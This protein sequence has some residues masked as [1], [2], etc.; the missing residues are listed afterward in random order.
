MLAN[1]NSKSLAVLLI[2]AVVLVS[3]SFAT[4]PTDGTAIGNLSKKEAG[5][6]NVVSNTSLPLPPGK[7]TQL[8]N[9]GRAAKGARN[10]YHRDA[11]LRSAAGMCLCPECTARAGWTPESAADAVSPIRPVWYHQIRGAIHHGDPR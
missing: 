9:A 3:V 4:R 6:S 10:L 7:Q 8:Y 1:R 5:F 2:L 11:H